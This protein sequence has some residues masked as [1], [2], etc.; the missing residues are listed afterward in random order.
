[1]SDQEDYAA[2]AAQAVGQVQ[3]DPGTDSGQTV[4]QM[5]EQLAEQK[6]RSALSDFEQQ[7]AA[8]MK[9][10]ESQMAALSASHQAQVQGLQR[11]IASVRQQAG[12]PDAVRLATALNERVASI[13]AAHPA[14]GPGHF[15]GVASQ[16]A[17][18]KDAVDA[19]AGGTSTD[20]ASAERTASGIITWF[21]KRH[22]RLSNTVLEM[23]GAAVDEAERIL[24]EL[25]GLASVASAAA[26]VL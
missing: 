14:L 2:Q 7:I 26:Q 18:L 17:S 20:T 4:E 6:V 22:P 21:E 11:Q 5:A 1:M 19:I 8:A 15:A 3:A 23:G 16:A 24:E 13:A 12:P 10:A 9:N 25:P